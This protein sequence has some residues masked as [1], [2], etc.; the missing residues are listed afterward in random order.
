MRFRLKTFSRKG[1]F[2]IVEMVVVVAVVA[3]LVGLMVPA[4]TQVQ[5]VAKT[6]A[7]K[8]QFA[9]IE[10]G[11]ETFYNEK[12]NY[13]PSFINNA[14]IDY[15]GAEILAEAMVGMD[16]FGVHPDTVWDYEANR[17]PP[18]CPNPLYK[19]G[20][21]LDPTLTSEDVEQNIASRKGPYLEPDKANAVRVGDIYSALPANTAR[22]TFVLAD[23]F[24][25]VTHVTGRYKTGMPIL[26]FKA[27]KNKTLHPK[28]HAGTMNY[29]NYIYSFKD[30]S[31]FNNAPTPFDGEEHP[32]SELST[33][34]SISSSGA[35]L[36]YLATR[37]PNYSDPWRPYNSESY[38]L[39]SAGADGY[40]GT[41]DDVYNF[42]R[43]KD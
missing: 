14:G 7:Q 16:G 28:I 6:L 40:D 21:D 34:P 37:N 20:I 10:V 35:M 33:V 39:L 25:K 27:R 30:N 36:F 2:T 8:A 31:D 11:L 24:K 4:I 23:S 9:S 32:M 26:Y 5:K 38:I 13:P 3:I 22:D 17:E 42:D 18:F 43:P 29:S 15:H 19:P 12:G 41:D 1:G